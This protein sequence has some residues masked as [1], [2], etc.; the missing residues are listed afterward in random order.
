[1]KRLGIVPA[2]TAVYEGHAYWPKW[3]SLTPA[4]QESRSPPHDGLLGDGVDRRGPPDRPR[5]RLPQGPRQS[6]TTPSSSSCPTTAPTATRCTTCRPPHRQYDEKDMDDGA[7]TPASRASHRVQPGLGPG[8]DDAVQALQV[9]HVRR[10][11]L[12]AGDRLGPGI[13]GGAVEQEVAHVTDVARDHLRAGR[14]EAPGHRIP[15]RPDLPL[16]GKSMVNCERRARPPPVRGNEEA[17]GWELGGQQGPRKGDWKIVYTRTSPGRGSWSS[18]DLAKDR[19]ESRDLAERDPQKLGEMI[20]AWKQYVAETGTLEI[21]GLATAPATA[22]PA[23]LPRPRE[24]P[25]RAQS[26]AAARARRPSPD[27]TRPGRAMR[28]RALLA[29]PWLT[30]G[31]GPRH[32]HRHGPRWAAPGRGAARRHCRDRMRRLPPPQ[33]PPCEGSKHRHAMAPRPAPPACRPTST[34]PASTARSRPPASPA[35]WNASS[36]A[37]TAPTA[38][39]PTSR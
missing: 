12:G 31:R 2:D 27:P 37:P 38:G 35:S 10:R 32:G 4:Q 19:T 25:E 6:W 14:R 26:Q 20:V 24:E 21:E 22:T 33:G 17:V 18:T 3:E 8:G 29:R 34:T 1:M 9:V 11:H 23:V 36:C 16:R 5:A 13:K 30:A 28:L 39:P 7:P 15:G